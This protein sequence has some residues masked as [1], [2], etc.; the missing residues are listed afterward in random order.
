MAPFDCYDEELGN[1]DKV[2]GWAY[3]QV[4][5]VKVPAEVERRLAGPI[6]PSKVLMGQW[7][8]RMKR[9]AGAAAA[10]AAGV[11]AVKAKV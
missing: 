6:Y 10:A 5:P 4:L 8:E 11:G 9:A 7:A 1:G 2:A 3:P